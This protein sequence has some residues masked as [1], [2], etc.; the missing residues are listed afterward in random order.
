MKNTLKSTILALSMVMAGWTAYESNCQDIISEINTED[1]E[2]LASGYT[3]DYYSSNDQYG[4]S[5]KRDYGELNTDD[6]SDPA[7]MERAIERRCPLSTGECKAYWAQDRFIKV[8]GRH[9]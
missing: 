7:T 4:N 6:F 8:Q 3:F 9:N 1:V 5:V 2:A